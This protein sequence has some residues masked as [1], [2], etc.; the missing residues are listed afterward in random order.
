[1]P[2]TTRLVPPADAVITEPV[3][4][5]LLRA[6]VRVDGG[7]EDEVLAHCLKAAREKVENYTGLYFAGSQRLQLTFDLSEPYVLPA[8]VTVVSVSGF[9]TS[10]EEL[11]AWSLEEYRKGIHI[12]RELHWSE[13][14][15]QQ[16]AV[17]VDLPANPVCPEVAKSAILE[18]AAEWYRNRETSSSA[19]VV[20][21]ELPVSWK[22]KL[23]ELRPS[24]LL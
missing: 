14:I 16:Y 8:A 11:E 18:I 7:Q 22:V 15:S 10:L 9:F 13:A 19:G 24:P 1:M 5:S 12:N 23:A 17:V 6:W 20:P 4:L 21:R 2:I 3:E